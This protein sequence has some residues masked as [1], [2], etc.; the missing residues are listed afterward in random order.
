MDNEVLE[1]DIEQPVVPEKGQGKDDK[2]GKD[3]VQERIERLERRLAESEQSERY[4]A[5]IA[6]NGG[7]GRQAEPEE[8]DTPDASEFL[9]DDETEELD[10]DTPEKLVDEFAATGVKA[11][12]KRGFIT[13]ADALKL[14]TEAAIKVSRE[15]IG[16]ERVKMSSDQQLIAEFPELKDPKSDLYKETAKIYQQ[17]VAMDPNAK[18]SPAVLLMA[19]K[20]AKLS[21]KPAP[22]RRD[23][24]DDDDFEETESER[25]DRARSQDSRP[26]GRGDLDDHDDRLGDEARHII[27][28]FGIT[29]EEFKAAQKD[30]MRSRPR[31]RR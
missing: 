30:T 24:D 9:E 10:G 29:E 22:S 5:G 4:W 17:A 19:A 6:K 18:K 15:L 26:R 23:R 2:G 12:S 14:A 3:P 20:A 28:G 1:R 7:G 13:K 27:S 21:L 31:G 16:R 11:L 8:D 25:R